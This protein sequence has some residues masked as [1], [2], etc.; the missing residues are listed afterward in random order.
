MK[1]AA[2][3]GEA[4]DKRKAAQNVKSY[5]EAGELRTSKKDYVE[6]KEEQGC[7]TEAAA[8]EQ[9]V[10]KAPGIKRK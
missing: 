10:G 6:V 2:A 4:D 5:K 7:E 1:D 8:L 3:D 9:T